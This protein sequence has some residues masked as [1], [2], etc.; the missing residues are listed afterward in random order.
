MI[1][2]I[3]LIAAVA[4]PLWNI[5]LIVRIEQRK[6]SKDLSVSWALGVLACILLML[7]AS[8]MSSDVILRA[9]GI[10][11]AALFSAVTIQILRYR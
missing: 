6:S 7:P 5:P 10:V 11:N 9:F 8:L 1:Q 3:G 4:M 2:M